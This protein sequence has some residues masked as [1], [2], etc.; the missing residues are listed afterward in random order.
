VGLTDYFLDFARL[1]ADWVMLLLIV[2]SILSVGVMIDRFLWFRGRDTDTDKFARELR[3]AFERDEL[4][5]LIGKYKDSTVVPVRVALR[6]VEERDRGAHA[7]TEA[8]QAERVRWRRAGDQNL[9]VLGT[10]GNNVPFVGLFGTVLGI[11][12]SFHDL[13]GGSMQNSQAVM[14]GIAE[15]LVATGVGL[16]VALPAVATYNAFMRHCETTAAAADALAHD[17]LAH[18]RADRSGDSS[19]AKTAKSSSVASSE[20]AGPGAS[21]PGAGSEA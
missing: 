12:R 9:I 2:L 5:R 7:A 1:G 6:G 20:P 16:V 8:M 10:L 17:I 3:G 18:L 15:A 14:A 11:I 21:T 19:D 4:D 13:S